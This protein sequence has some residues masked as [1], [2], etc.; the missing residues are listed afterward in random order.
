[1]LNDR[2]K[3]FCSVPEMKDYEGKISII[4]LTGTFTRGTAGRHKARATQSSDIE[5]SHHISN[6]CS[7]SIMLRTY[8]SLKLG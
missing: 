2:R 3:L 5:P 8:I 1:M 4:S 6:S 7:E